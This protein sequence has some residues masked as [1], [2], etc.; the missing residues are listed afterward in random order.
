[1]GVADQYGSL[2]KGKSAT[3]FISAGDALDMRTNQVEHAFI[4][5][6]SIDL[7]NHHERLHRKYQMKYDQR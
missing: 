5:G 7:D 2:E 6:R 4:D 1:M 3:L